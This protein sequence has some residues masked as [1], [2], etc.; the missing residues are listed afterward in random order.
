[1]MLFSSIPIAA[2]LLFSAVASGAEIEGH[3]FNR[4]ITI[5]LENQVRPPSP[6]FAFPHT[7]NVTTPH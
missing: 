2:A 1:M 6:P 3:A 7:P 4:F 5:W